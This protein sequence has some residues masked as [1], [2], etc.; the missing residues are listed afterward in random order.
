MKFPKLP[1]LKPHID[2]IKKGT[3]FLREWEDKLKPYLAHYVPKKV[4]TYHLTYLSLVW[5]F[6]VIVSGFLAETNIEWLWLSCLLIIFHYITDSLDGAIGRIRNT[7]LIKWGYFM[8][9]FLDYVFFTSL[10]MS[11]I[12]I[13][14]GTEAVAIFILALIQIGFMITIYLAYGVTH[15]L[16]I[17]FSG[18]GPTEVRILYILFNIFLIIFGTAIP[19]QLMAPFAIIIGT[20]LI[21]NVYITQKMIWKLDMEIKAK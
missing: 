1:K 17:S 7:G 6:G 5:S 10:I 3:W 12:Y 11:Y 4:E 15:T 8:D 2:K 9:H 21:I 19:T 13:F 18:F 14:P 16:H 20:A